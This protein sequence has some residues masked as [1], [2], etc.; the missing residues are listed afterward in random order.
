LI[1]SSENDEHG[2]HNPVAADASRSRTSRRRQAALQPGGGAIIKMGAE[3]DV[4]S[5]V[6]E[7]PRRTVDDRERHEDEQLITGFRV[8]E[9]PPRA[10]V[11]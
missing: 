1:S 9:E 3:A 7:P 5:R 6:A 11:D 10:R 4:C 2:Q 8:P